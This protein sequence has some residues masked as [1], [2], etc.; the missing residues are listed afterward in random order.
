VIVPP[1]AQFTKF[2]EV[3]E[4]GCARVAVPVFAVV[5]AHSPGGVV[6]VFNRYRKVWEL[7]G[8]FIDAGETSREAAHRELFEEAACHARDLHWLGLVEVNDGAAHFG[9]VFRGH[10]DAVPPD[11]RNDEIGGIG[12]WNCDDSPKPLGVTDQALL[13]RFGGSLAQ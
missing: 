5:I 4:A 13:H 12:C 3:S 9:A 6:L 1:L 8:W 10:V 7:P 11:V 2:H